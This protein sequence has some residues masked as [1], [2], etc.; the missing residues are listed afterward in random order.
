MRGPLLILKASM[1][2][3]SRINLR[4]HHMT[5]FDHNASK[6]A[7]VNPATE[8]K[9]RETRDAYQMHAQR[10]TR[11]QVATAEQLARGLR[12]A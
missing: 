9:R 7:P 10:Y 6:A 8:Q 4:K 3:A 11:E 2:G 5:Y 1:L 12:F